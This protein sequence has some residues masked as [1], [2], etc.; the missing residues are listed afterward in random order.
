MRIQLGKVALCLCLIVPGVWAQHNLS[1]TTTTEE[2]GPEAVRSKAQSR[3]TPEAQ[4]AMSNASTND[5]ASALRATPD[6]TAVRAERRRRFEAARARLENNEGAASEDAASQ[7][8][9]TGSDALTWVT[10]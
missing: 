4:G 9:A 8:G 1:Q 7:N 10:L 5:A 3:E 6:E 2:T